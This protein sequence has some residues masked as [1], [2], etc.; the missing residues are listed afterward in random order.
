[1]G[2]CGDTLGRERVSFSGKPLSPL[3][4]PPFSLQGE[5]REEEENEATFILKNDFVYLAQLELHCGLRA[6]KYSFHGPVVFGKC[7]KYNLI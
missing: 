6:C 7:D 4:S 3:S 2:H 1:V 5:V